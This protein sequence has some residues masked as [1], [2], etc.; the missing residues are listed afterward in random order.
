[1]NTAAQTVTTPSGFG[2]AGGAK[3]VEPE[4]A[5]TNLRDASS[6]LEALLDD[7]GN[8]PD[9]DVSARDQVDDDLD[10]GDADDSRNPPVKDVVDDDDS[11]TDDHDDDDDTSD[12]ND[13]SDD[14]SDDSDED[15][16]ELS[17]LDELAE[18]LEMEADDLKDLK[19]TFNAAGEQVT[20]PISE[21]ISGYQKDSDYRKQTAALAEERNTFTS[22]VKTQQE[23]YTRQS[24]V[25]AQVLMNIENSIK[26]AVKNPDMDALRQ[27]DPAEW[28]ARVT[29]ANAR[30]GNLEQLRNAASDNFKKFQMEAKKAFLQ[31][32]GQI[33]QKDVEGW[34]DEKLKVAQD[35]MRS[36]GFSD[37]E[38]PEIADARLIKAA[39]AFDAVM[40]ENAALK[41]QKAK[42]KKAA[43]KVK[44]KVPKT[45]K[46][47]TR[48][49]AKSKRPNFDKAKRRLKAN[50]VGKANT[51]AAADAIEQLLVKV[52]D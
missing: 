4:G 5:I 50:P 43:T 1:M 52:E 13:D 41:E 19:V 22:T 3:P 28:N 42:G 6:Q 14:D 24:T 34:G 10:N 35:V 20:V 51:Q 23:T 40:K 7:D 26:S 15:E 44:E 38:I 36:Y 46:P 30:L 25:L 8:S 9:H 45:L 39:L 29:E 17:T 16:P 21:I 27:S 2:A 47:G 31:T 48:A 11:D 18:A 49:K 32:Q 37:E 12:D 33:L